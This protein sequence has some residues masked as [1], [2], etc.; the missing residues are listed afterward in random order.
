MS[1]CA[2]VMLVGDE[3]IIEQCLRE[4]DRTFDGYCWEHITRMNQ[5]EL[6]LHEICLMGKQQGHPCICSIKRRHT[7]EGEV[8]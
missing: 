3:A 7:E 2:Y 8:A 5:V 1:R 6:D 4:A